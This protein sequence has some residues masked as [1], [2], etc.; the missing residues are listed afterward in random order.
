M[1]FEALG[2]LS[3]S[4]DGKAVTLGGR[5]QRTLLAVLLLH[6]NETVS[7]DKLVEALWREHPP[8]TWAETLDSYLYRLRKLLG[9]DRIVRKAGGYVVRLEPGEFDV[10]EFEQLVT[11]ARAAA[12]GDDHAAALRELTVALEL[13]RGPAWGDLLDN[14]AVEADAQ[15]L[16]ELRL[17]AL[18]SRFEAELAL[19]HGPDLAPELE[20]LVDEH[21]LRERLIA[22]LM[23]SLYRAGRQTNALDAFQAARG[24]LVEALGLEPGPGLRELQQRILE[25][26]PTLGAPRRLPSLSRSSRPRSLAVAALAALAALAVVLRHRARKLPGTLLCSPAAE[27]A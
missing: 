26:D 25:H 22:S 19:G 6:R 1:R 16:E 7:R 3:V 27:Q 10:D 15:R 5:K 11:G 13:W 2:P 14:Q 17:T 24:R 23:L 8:P 21:P 4:Q 20:Q 18:E 12:E 9:H